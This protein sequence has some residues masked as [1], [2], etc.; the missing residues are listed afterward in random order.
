MVDGASG[1]G[2]AAPLTA[3]ES[4][5]IPAL[6][7][8]PSRLFVETTTRCNLRCRM[9]VKQTGGNCIVEG[10]MS[11]EI[12]SALEPAL[13]RIEALIL[14]GIGEPLLHP[15]LDTFIRRARALMPAEAWIGFQ[16]NGL[17]LSQARAVALVEVGL[18]RICISMDAVSPETFRNIREG[19]ELRDLEDALAALRYAK[20]ARGS[21]LQ[22]GLEFVVMRENAR[23]LPQV[24]AWAAAR[25]VTFAIVS[26]LLPY[27]KEHMDSVAYETNTDEALEFFKPWRE[28]AQREGI[29][30]H[31]FFRVIMN[32]IRSPYDQRVVD[33][34][35]EMQMDARS[36]DLFFNLKNLLQ[37][38]EEWFEEI[39]AIFAEAEQVARETG[40]DLQLPAITPRSERKCDFVEK[41]AAFISWDG[42]VHNCYFLWHQFSCYSSRSK[43]YVKPRVFGNLAGQG[44]R[45]IWNNPEFI[46]YRQ[47]VLRHEY[48]VCSN[49]S[50]VPC[51]YVYTEEFKQDCF[52]NEVACGDCFWCMGLFRCLQ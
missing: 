44:I 17:L 46:A 21:T 31:R 5:V 48:P 52:T 12:F 15:G 9:C 7:E 37:R 34:V 18:D 50:V 24:L 51:E 40:L 3:P 32:Y 6:R 36:R 30:L 16:S 29:D 42:G 25:G 28:R 8:Y 23:E 20:A 38:D 27:E 22:I 45:E 4:G 26:H 43:K 14:N 2:A 39:S 41:G 33:F 35:W 13:P 47:K 10:D 19:G 11:Q 49:C 1:R